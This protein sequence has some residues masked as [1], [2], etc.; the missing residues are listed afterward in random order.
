MAPMW[1]LSAIHIMQVHWI[2]WCY[3]CSN[4]DS[5]FW[6]AASWST[7]DGQAFR[8]WKEL[9][10]VNCCFKWSCFRWS[11]EVVCWESSLQH[12]WGSIA[13][14]PCQTY[15]C[16]TLYAWSKFDS[17]LFISFKSCQVFEPFGQVELVQLP[18]DPLTGLCKG[19]GFVQVSI[20]IRGNFVFCWH[21]IL[22]TCIFII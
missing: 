22:I 10:S 5:S 4:G 19:F 12:Q 15:C 1:F 9:S 21:L 3:V 11:K 13:T 18:L 14:G 16:L 8:G 2:L 7:S 17:C 20:S 6:S